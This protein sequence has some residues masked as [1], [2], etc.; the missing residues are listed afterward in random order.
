MKEL[1]KK[2]FITSFCLTMFLVAFP[3]SPPHPNGGGGP[4]VG[5]VPVGGNAPIDG[6]ISILLVLAGSYGTK[7]VFRNRE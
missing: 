1:I 5:N 4:G 7:K 6:G 2:L 3:Q